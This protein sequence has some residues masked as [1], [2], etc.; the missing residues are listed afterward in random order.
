MSLTTQELLATG[1]VQ[2]PGAVPL[3]IG[4]AGDRRRGPS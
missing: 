3:V 4:V 1:L 2:D